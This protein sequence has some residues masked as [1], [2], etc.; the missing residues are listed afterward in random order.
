MRIGG[1]QALIVPPTIS[2]FAQMPAFL[3]RLQRGLF[4]ATAQIVCLSFICFCCPGFFNARM[5]VCVC[6]SVCVWVYI[7]NP[8]YL[9]NL[10]LLTGLLQRAYVCVCVCVRAWGRAH[11]PGRGWEGGI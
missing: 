11:T 5:C 4:G 7:S 10:P 2:S 3:E 8:V 9:L 6:T 1:K